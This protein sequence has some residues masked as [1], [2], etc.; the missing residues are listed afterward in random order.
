MKKILVLI[1]VS[2]IVLIAGCESSSPKRDQIPFL[3]T[4]IF[5]LQTAVKEMNRAAIDSLLSVK[6][7]SKQ[8]GSDSLVSF[9][10]GPDGGFG[11]ERF[12]NY[13]IEYT[14]DK[15]RIECYVMDS[16]SSTD[17]PITFFLTHEHDMWL[18]T[19]FEEGADETEEAASD[20]SQ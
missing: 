12:G 17:R 10:Y 3:K 5:E 15:A 16:T 18:F 8:Q 20:T 9:V 4:R 14:T 2:A 11:F 6:I 7:V 1:S 13:S 19:S